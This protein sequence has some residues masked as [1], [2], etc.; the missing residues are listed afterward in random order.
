MKYVFI[1]L[2]YLSVAVRIHSHE[3]SYFSVKLFYLWLSLF[4]V[5]EFTDHPG[6]SHREGSVRFTRFSQ[7]EVGDIDGC[8]A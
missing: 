7:L 2:Q 4:Y 3:A 5:W 1:P 6:P 8:E